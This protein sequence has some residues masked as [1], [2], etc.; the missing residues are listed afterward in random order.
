MIHAGENVVHVEV[1]NSLSSLAQHA[2][3]KAIQYNSSHIQ[4]TLSRH[5]TTVVEAES[6]AGSKHF[7]FH[8]EKENCYGLH[9]EVSQSNMD[10]LLRSHGSLGQRED[11]G[12]FPAG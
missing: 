6:W 1:T 12:L 11:T 3:P 8:V 9:W 10:S 5:G 2:D 7:L 4:V